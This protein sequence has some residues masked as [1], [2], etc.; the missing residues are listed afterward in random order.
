MWAWI[1]KLMPMMGWGDRPG[2]LRG[3]ADSLETSLG[4]LGI[5]CTW[6]VHARR[7]C[8]FFALLLALV[9]PGRRPGDVPRGV[10]LGGLALVF[11]AMWGFGRGARD[12]LL[13]PYGFDILLLIG[14]E[15][16][17]VCL[18]SARWSE[19]SKPTNIDHR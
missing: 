4:C 10:M 14:V 8:R 15:A 12:W 3:A 1:A 11:L 2:E 18:F 9:M 6:P 7:G 17:A 13:A 19:A 5:G 16:V